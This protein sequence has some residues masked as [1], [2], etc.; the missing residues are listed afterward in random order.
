[1]RTKLPKKGKVLKNENELRRKKGLY[2]GK[3]RGNF[4][5][6][7][8]Y[9]FWQIQFTDEAS[10]VSLESLGKQKNAA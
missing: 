3:Y 5:A 4:L 10:F 8:Q 2:F 9:R 6:N 7:F 1:M